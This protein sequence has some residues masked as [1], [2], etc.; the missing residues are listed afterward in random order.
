[1]EDKEQAKALSPEHLSKLWA[2][3]R[4]DN[5]M[6]ENVPASCKKSLESAWKAKKI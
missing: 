5:Q 6:E 3:F 2:N 1:M 4:L